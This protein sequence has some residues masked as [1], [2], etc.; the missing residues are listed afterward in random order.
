MLKNC[1]ISAVGS[2]ATEHPDPI[3][4]NLI[5][6][7]CSWLKRASSA[8]VRLHYINVM[9]NSLV[10]YINVVYDYISKCVSLPNDCFQPVSQRECSVDCIQGG[11]RAR[12]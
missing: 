3:Q 9:S 2:V 10:Q 6:F 12:C 1:V 5:G 7:D 11:G 8:I 4:P